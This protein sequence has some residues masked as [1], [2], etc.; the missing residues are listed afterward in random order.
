MEEVS[1]TLKKENSFYLNSIHN[2]F[3]CIAQNNKQNA[4][5]GFTICTGQHDI[6]CPLTL[7]LSEEITP[8]KPCLQGKEVSFYLF[9]L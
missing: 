4:W 6:L 2:N 9:F 3:I 8:Q 5:M 1:A 7:N